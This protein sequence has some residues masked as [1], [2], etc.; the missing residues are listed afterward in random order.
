MDDGQYE[1]GEILWQDL[2]TEVSVVPRKAA[3]AAAEEDRKYALTCSPK[4][5][6]DA[7]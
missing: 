4:E 2:G 3:T 6:C 5:E 7:G 1:V